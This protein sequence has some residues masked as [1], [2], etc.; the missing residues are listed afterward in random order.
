MGT[1]IRTHLHDN[2][3]RALP[4]SDQIVMERTAPV[5]KSADIDLPALL[6]GSHGRPK[7]NRYKQ[8]FGIIV[9]VQSE[10]AQ[11]TLFHKLKAQGHH[12]KVVNT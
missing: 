2:K 1:G 10:P 3:N 7:D 11:K 5:P 6:P 8:Q 4:P 9:L 12:C